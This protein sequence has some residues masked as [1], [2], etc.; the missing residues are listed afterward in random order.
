MDTISAEDLLERYRSGYSLEQ[1]F[2]TDAHVFDLEW[3]HIWKKYWLFAGTT[4]EI[5]KP[6]D[7]FIYNKTIK[8]L[9]LVNN[10]NVAE[11]TAQAFIN[12][13]AAITKA[14]QSANDIALLKDAVEI[15]NNR[16][17]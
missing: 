15:Y 13:E 3:E 8:Q 5:P 7:Y 14:K 6:G 2:Y 4:A 10:K 16:N 1:P 17:N 12:C 9:Q 11:V